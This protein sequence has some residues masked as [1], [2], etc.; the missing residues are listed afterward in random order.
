MGNE[1]NFNELLK[2]KGLKIT[3]H[4]TAVLNILST[5]CKPLTAEEIYSIFKEQ[6]VSINL[7]SIYKILDSLSTNNVI[8][9]FFIGDKN[10]TCYEMNTT[11]AKHHLI[12]KECNG[13][14]PLENCPLCAYKNNLKDDLDFDVTEHHLEIYGYCKTC[15]NNKHK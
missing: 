12:C 14:F 9:K 15:K 10:I 6:Q 8:S 3:K 5:S 4:R 11:E 2:S 13:V 7:S 1:G